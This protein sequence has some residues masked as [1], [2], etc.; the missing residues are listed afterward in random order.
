MGRDWRAFLRD[1]EK[2]PKNFAKAIIEH[3]DPPVYVIEKL[4]DRMFMCDFCWSYRVDS[5]FLCW[6]SVCEEHAKVY[7]GEKTKLEWRVCPNC[8]EANSEEEIL[9]RVED[10]DEEFWLMHQDIQGEKVKEAGG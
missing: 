10:Q 3:L 1:V 4:R 9:K 6:K 8:Q 2:D 5:C 7:I